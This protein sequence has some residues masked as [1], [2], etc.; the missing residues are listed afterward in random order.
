MPKAAYVQFV[1]DLSQFTPLA[2]E[3]KLLGEIREASRSETEKVWSVIERSVMADPA[4]SVG[5]KQRLNELRP[6]VFDGLD[7]GKVTFLVI[8]SGERFIGASGLVAEAGA[9]RH[10][11]TGIHIVNEYR[12]RGQGTQLLAE[13]LAWLKEKGLKEA[14]AITKKGSA[15]EKYLYGKFGGRSNPIE[16]VPP[17]PKFSRK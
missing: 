16:S 1:W 6:M 10:L 14:A 7:S 3:A 15:A 9:A 17:M 8:H 13:S 5:L 11:V 12:C 4:W 2:E